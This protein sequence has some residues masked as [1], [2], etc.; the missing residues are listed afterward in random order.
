MPSIDVDGVCHAPREPQRHE[1]ATMNNMCPE[2]SSHHTVAERLGLNLRG[3]RTVARQTQ[4]ETATRAGIAR[5]H[6]AALESGS[7]SNGGP[8]NPRLNTLLDLASALGCT[9]QD[10]LVGI[11]V[12]KSD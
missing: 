8:A 1:S 5:A 7:S 6:Y 2:P 10:L 12:N 4:A 3:L 11:H 9:L